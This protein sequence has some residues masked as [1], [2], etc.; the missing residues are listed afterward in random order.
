LNE[1][2]TEASHDE[3]KE[4]MITINPIARILDNGLQTNW[5]PVIQL[6]FFEH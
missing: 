1:A 4:T 2:K 3:N 6:K 5:Q